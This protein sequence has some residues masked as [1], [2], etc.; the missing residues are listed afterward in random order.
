MKDNE[1]LRDGEA[2]ASVNGTE[3]DFYEGM[4]KFRAPAVRFF[5]GVK[6]VKKAE[7]KE[8]SG[9]A[10]GDWLSVLSKIVG[11]DLPK[12]HPKKGWRGTKLRPLFLKKYN[13][14]VKSKELDNDIK[15]AIINY[16]M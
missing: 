6:G 13:E 1:I 10:D 12:P 16:F 5:N 14:I 4:A 9:A 2:I 11:V 8:E 3:L 15:K 7:V